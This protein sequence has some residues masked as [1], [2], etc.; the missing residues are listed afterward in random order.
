[1]KPSGHSFL[2]VVG[3]STWRASIEIAV[4]L[5]SVLLATCSS[6]LAQNHPDIDISETVGI[7]FSES[8]DGWSVDELLLRDT[9]REK[10]LAAC[11]KRTT[12]GQSA[13]ADKTFMERLIQ[14]RKAGKL[15]VKTTKRENHDLESW[16]PI[17]EIA[18][19]QMTDLHGANIDQ[20]LCDPELLKKFDALVRSMGSNHGTYEARKAAMQLR[21]SRRLQPE[22][23]VRVVDW[24]RE[25]KTLPL[26]EA[27]QNI[28]ML[29]TNPG[30][31]L[32]R[33][34]TGY[35]YI[36]QS[37]NLKSRLS[38]HLDNSD[39]K[40]LSHYLKSNAASEITLDMHIFAQDSPAIQTVVREAY[41][42]DLIRTR[43]PRFNIAP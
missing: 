19:R 23:L 26:E 13:I 22:L 32:F 43:H 17:A 18:S 6:A 5:A 8:H 11:R 42:S 30:I 1:M 41:E 31:Y 15:D 7:A 10:F 2:L 14:I 9:L 3:R 27:I 35:L 34:S 40:A 28:S 33:D 38:K 4:M 25:I 12:N 37:N 36:G 24:K 21:K 20:W 29:P 39:R 16:F